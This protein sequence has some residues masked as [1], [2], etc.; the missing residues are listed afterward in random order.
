M[1][2]RVATLK[3]HFRSQVSVHQ[4]KRVQMLDGCNYIVK[5]VRHLVV[6]AK[7]LQYMFH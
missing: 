1:A 7:V 6:A 3:D 5:E 4:A 2:A